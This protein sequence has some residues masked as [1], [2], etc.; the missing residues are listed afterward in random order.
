MR[1]YRNF[2]TF[3]Y[4]I[5]AMSKFFFFVALLFSLS[6]CMPL[7]LQ[8]RY[9]MLD[10]SQQASAVLITDTKTG[11]LVYSKHS[12]QF[13]MPAS[14]MKLLTFL[15]ANRVLT[16]AVPAF[17]YKETADTLYFWGTGDPSLLH[18][19]F[20]GHALL[21]KLAQTNKVL[22]YA[23]I[24][25]NN[26]P[27]GDG[28]SWEDYQ[29]DYSAEISQLPLYNNMMEISQS[30]AKWTIFP[31]FF[32]GQTIPGTSKN[33]LRDRLSNQLVLPATQTYKNEHIGFVGSTALTARLLADTLHKPIWLRPMPFD[34]R[35][36]LAY[37]G[38]LDSLLKPMLH[39]SDNQIAEQMLYLIA[40][41]KGWVGPTQRI[42]DSLKKEFP[43]FA[44]L[45]WADGS[46][47]SRYN[48]MRPK[49]LVRILALLNQE[50]PQA[51]LHALL[52]Q[53]GRSGTLKNI[54]LKNPK[55]RI[56]AKSG[57][58]GNTYNLSGYYESSLGKMYTF[59]VMC[60]LGNR[61]TTAMKKDVVEL[62]NMLN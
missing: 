14:N 22:A 44:A 62:L 21:T 29:Y 9:R 41:K 5:F 60:N 58:F 6:S 12:D 45:H 48:L 38:S 49:D 40:A 11:K 1:K 61:P 26:R 24:D 46:G 52:P 37:A 50:I 39:N 27:Y 42:I 53:T 43:E 33:L 8:T 16:D 13:M 15:L 35:S 34:A 28:W 2:D 23:D 51:R 31:A 54:Q 20:K 7:R 59:S 18:P 17:R 47:M 36:S 32:A 3:K 10:M 30:N 19:R 56:W 4:Q 55:A 25:Q 57:S